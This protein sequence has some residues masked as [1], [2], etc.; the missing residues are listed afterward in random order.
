[1]KKILVIA[2]VL[3]VSSAAGTSHAQ[4]AKT[5]AEL[6]E[7]VKNALNTAK[8]IEAVAK[9]GNRVARQIAENNGEIEKHN[10]NE[11]L[12]DKQNEAE[13]EAYNKRSRK[14]NAT[15]DALNARIL[16]LVG[17]DSMLRTHI[18]ILMARI[19]LG[20]FLGDE[21]GPWVEE[22]KSCAAIPD[23]EKS[24]GCLNRAWERRP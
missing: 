12:I 24:V 4:A 20:I 19:R 6:Q 2:T 17:E 8:E 10:A 11:S 15:R 5:M 7:I 16:Q 1:M 13:V 22:V 18:G 23:L 21:V 3:L 9:S 14:L